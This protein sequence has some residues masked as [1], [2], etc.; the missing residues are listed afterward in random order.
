[1][2]RLFNPRLLN[3][4]LAIGCW[5][6]V[7]SVLPAQVNLSFDVG[8]GNRGYRYVEKDINAFDGGLPRG[9]SCYFAPRIGFV[10]SDDVT[11]GVQ[12]GA[13]YS[14]YDF[15]EGFYN[16]EKLGWQ[17]SATVNQTML[18]TSA[19][20]FLR[21]RCLG[22]GRLSLHVELSGG[23]GLGWGWD[24][25]TEFRATDG[26]NLEMQRQVTEQRLC[27]QVVPVMNYAFSSHVG[28]DVYL[29]L[30]ALTFSS[31]VTEQW[32][33]SIKDYPPVEESESKTTVQEFNV[34]MNALN[35]N[36]LTV[37]FSYIF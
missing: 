22:D 20:A 18:R 14:S 30:V 21:L 1:M 24:K 7:S 5:L 33:Y 26:W 23:Y 31:T 19:R 11:V 35:T 10:L 25:R 28:M 8:Y 15:V 17:Q 36:L 9:Q 32:P 2:L 37:G 29:N 12:L 4:A 6:L 34:G 3:R 13:E 27:M 16:T